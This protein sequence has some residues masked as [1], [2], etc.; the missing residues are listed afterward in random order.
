M[1]A[2]LF[3]ANPQ[4]PAAKRNIYLIFTAVLVIS[5]VGAC[6]TVAQRQAQAI[7]VNTKESGQDSEEGIP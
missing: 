6:S 5:T 3:R 7:T 4:T 2:I 1:D